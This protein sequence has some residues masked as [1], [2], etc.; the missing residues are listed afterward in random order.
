MPKCYA[1]QYSTWKREL[2]RFEI[3]KRTVLVGHSC[4]GGFIARWLSDNRDLRV[5]RVVLVAPWIDPYRTRTSD[6]FDFEIDPGM[7]SRTEGLAIFNSDNDAGDIQESAYALRDKVKDCY[8]REFHDYGHFCKENLG[9]EAFP[10]LLELLI[11][12]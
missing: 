2:E 8:F 12:E 6:F 11:K 5:G 3:N 9:S 10:E 4:G 7:A 1:P